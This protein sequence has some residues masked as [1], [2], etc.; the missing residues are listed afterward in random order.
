MLFLSVCCLCSHADDLGI[1]S[2]SRSVRTRLYF[3]S[4]S[5]LHSLLNVLRYPTDPG[6]C[7]FSAAGLE[8]LNQCEE[9]SY[10]TQVVIRVFSNKDNPGSLRAEVYFSPGAVGDPFSAQGRSPWLAPYHLLNASISCEDLISRLDDAIDASNERIG[11][12]D[13]E[14]VQDELAIPST[15]DTVVEP[16]SPSFASSF[17]S[18]GAHFFDDRAGASAGAGAGVGAGA[19]AGT[20]A[21]TGSPHARA[22]RLSGSYY[23]KIVTDQD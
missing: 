1:N 8:T 16:T 6:K 10:L 5:H 13:G 14:S 15:P 7:A 17:V 4:E 22:P 19:A 23:R 12:G 3:T 9:L 20:S 18:D 2:L 21:S 11:G